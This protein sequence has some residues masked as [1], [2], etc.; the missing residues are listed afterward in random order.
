MIMKFAEEQQSLS[1]RS[2]RYYYST[3]S[4]RQQRCYDK[5]LNGYLHHK[6]RITVEMD[7]R[8]DISIVNQAIVNDAP[9]LF[10]LNNY[11]YIY[12][13]FQRIAKVDPIYSLGILRSNQIKNEI[14]SNINR[15]FRQCSNKSDFEKVKTIH[16]YLLDHIK[17]DEQANS[18]S[19][20]G[21]LVENYAVCEGISKAFKYMADLIGLH[22]IIVYGNAYD[23][24]TNMMQSHSW[25]QVLV[26]G[27]NYHIDVTFDLTISELTGI[28]RYDYFLLSDAQIKNDHFFSSIPICSISFEYYTANGLY[29]ENKS[30]LKAI[31]AK[32]M[33]IED[34]IVVKM[35]DF[36]N[37]NQIIVQAVLD[38]ASEVIDKISMT[39]KD[40]TVECNE[41][42]M[43]FGI[44]VSEVS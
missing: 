33:Q 19:I 41:N 17:Y 34:T 6:K 20:V 36:K 40:I 23:S 32:H 10:Y 16:D 11:K 12:Y 31:L 27:I 13:E 22:S 4:I 38:I 26:D 43:I 15:I 14:N 24:S 42:R 21:A 25:N 1:N 3:L 8:E 7:N 9:E 44:K 29:A 28:R 2:Y 35:P 37:D 5:L 39:S 30:R 18:H